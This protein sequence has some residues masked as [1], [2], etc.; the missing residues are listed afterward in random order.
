MSQRQRPI[1]R[2]VVLTLVVVVLGLRQAAPR[3]ITGNID[4][5]SSWQFLDRFV[6]HNND[7][8]ADEAAVLSSEF[9]YHRDSR[10]NLLVYFNSKADASQGTGNPDT[11]TGAGAGASSESSTTPNDPASTSAD[12]ELRA[13]NLTVPETK[14]IPLDQPNVFDSG[15]WKDI[16]NSGMSCM[17]RDR[18]ARR[19]GNAFSLYKSYEFI[20]KDGRGFPSDPNSQWIK[21]SDL[22]TTTT[23]TET[24][25]LNATEKAPAPSTSVSV[26]EDNATMAKTTITVRITSSSSARTKTIETTTEKVASENPYPFRANK[27]FANV[28][29]R[30]PKWFYIVL[31][32]CLESRSATEKEL[33][34][35]KSSDPNYEVTASGILR[36]STNMARSTFCQGP[37]TRVKYRMTMRNGQSNIS[38][39]RDGEKEVATAFLVLYLGLLAYMFFV[40]R[41]LSKKRRVHHAA[42]LLFASIMLQT[43]AHIFNVNYW[44][45]LVAGGASENMERNVQGEHAPREVPWWEVTSVLADF[46]LVGSQCTLLLVCILIGKGWTVTRRKISAMGRVRLTA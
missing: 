35:G 44:Q 45:T 41:S 6:F 36:C 20:S 9:T 33:L 30:S 40:L 34:T 1:G 13:V 39:D 43:F 19:W 24:V 26:H 46:C 25:K 29:A 16:Y 32:N 11:S 42:R 38:Y 3:T 10:I 8:A 15:I 5:T 31:S 21:R 22:A 12:E 28:A 14:W 17:W 37:L 18:Q 23:T 4:T 27:F 2:A 7:D